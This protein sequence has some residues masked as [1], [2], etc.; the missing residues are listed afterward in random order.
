MAVPLFGEPGEYGQQDELTPA[1]PRRASRLGPRTRAVQRPRPRRATQPR[2]ER[3][4][5]EWH[6]MTAGERQAAWNQLRA[7]V[8]WLHDRYE[9]GTEERLPRCWAEHP[10]LIEELWALKA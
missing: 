6:E 8:T 2:P 1:V 9:L 5:A 4:L 10:G 3:R 7:W